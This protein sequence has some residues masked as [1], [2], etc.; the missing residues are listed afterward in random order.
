M[1]LSRSLLDR[2]VAWSPVLL[3][4]SLAAMTY[5]LDA[6]IAAP[7]APGDGARRHDP[8]I[9]VEN[10]RAVSF[11]K[12]GVATQILSA[13]R[14]DHFP[15]DDTT[16]LTVN[17]ELKKQ[18]DVFTTKVQGRLV[19]IRIKQL[20]TSVATVALDDPAAGIAEMKIRL[21]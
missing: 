21:K 15:D 17:G 18:N 4:G 14:A 11:D 9:F 8:D 3:L 2:L 7:S 13:A 16:Q 10:V 5:W 12:N 6:Q 20:T 1:D 19:L